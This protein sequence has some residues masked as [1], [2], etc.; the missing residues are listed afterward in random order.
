MSLFAS[1]LPQI[2]HVLGIIANE[3]GVNSG[4]GGWMPELRGILTVIIAVFTLMGSVYL[5]LATNMGARLAFLV[6]FAAFAGWMFLMGT[7][8]WTYGIGL[9]GPEPTWEA[10]Q[11]RTILQDTPSLSKAGALDAPVVVSDTASPPE[12]ADVVSAQFVSEGWKQLDRS[13]AAFGQASSQAEVFLIESKTFGPGE[14]KVMN[15]FDYGGERY[16][17][18]ADGKIDFIAFWHKPR[19]SVVEVAPVVPQRVE[20]GRAPAVPVVDTEQPH[21]YVYMIRN[22]GAKRRPAGLITIGSL[23]VFLIMC[24]LLHRR[25][26]RVVFNRSQ[27]ALPVQA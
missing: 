7:M 13:A 8:W 25:D 4:P 26:K 21:Q 23:I 27:P 15:V 22:M 24:W 1:A 2:N 20:P 3:A 12:V 6:S 19:Y 5:I 16:P 10:V 9:K 18:F 14:F 11:G 17:R